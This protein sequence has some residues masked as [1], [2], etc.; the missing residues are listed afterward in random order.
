MA[1][2]QVQGPDGATLSFPE[3]TDREVMK[4]AMA[5]R[6]PKQSASRETLPAPQIT[7]SQPSTGVGAF[8]AFG[9]G[10]VDGLS[11]GGIDYL[12]AGLGALTGLNGYENP[13]ASEKSGPNVSFGDF[14]GNLQRIRDFNK[15]VEAENPISS[16]TGNIVGST[17]G[18][19]KLMKSGLTA[20]RLAA[21][22]LP[23][24]QSKLAKLLTVAGV[25]AV[26]GAGYQVASNIGH[27]DDPTNG[28][29]LTAALGAATPAI[30][31]GVKKISDA[32]GLTQGLDKGSKLVFDAFTRNAERLGVPPQQILTQMSQPAP[33]QMRV[34]DALGKEGPALGRN[35]RDMSPDARSKLEQFAHERMAG[36]K[37]RLMNDVN[38]AGGLPE[39]QDIQALIEANSTSRQPQ[40]TNAYNQA[41]AAGYDLP[42][43][44]FE[45][46]LA[47]PAVKSAM[48][49]AI[50]TTKNR[51]AL[52]GQDENSQLA[53]YDA[54][55][56]IL[57]RKGRMEGNSELSGLAKMLRQTVDD[58]IPEYAGAR[59]LA[60]Q[61]FQAE[62]A[63]QLGYDG[64]KAKPGAGYVDKVLAAQKNNPDEIAKGYASGMAD[65]IAGTTSIDQAL[66]KFTQSMDGAAALKSALGP[67]AS[68]V[69]KGIERERGN[70]AMQREL[71]GGSQTARLLMETGLG[72]GLGAGLGFYQG[73]DMSSAAIGAAAGAGGRHLV[74]K[75]NENNRQKL[76]NRLADILLNG[77]TSHFSDTARK[78]GVSDAQLK[79]INDFV[80]LLSVGGG[81]AVSAQ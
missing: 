59:D 26:D 55:K 73:G 60:R 21:K 36:A 63:L 38:S 41:K 79:K 31:A 8:G 81:V 7:P 77:G 9:N 68:V 43:D 56:K 74:K 6:Y 62:E 40:I 48:D 16:T 24:A 1:D 64:A 76:G 5:K 58:N 65:A 32:T 27:G 19:G 25:G 18:V 80:K 2:I 53:V 20:E 11:F 67:K 78:V 17:L 22:A 3:G 69:E 46:L 15:R 47:A 51:I 45:S 71:T 12:D 72:G 44:P 4:A 75:M 28:I 57:D 30:G 14:S 66:G 13:F 52:G 70:M 29:G 23:T 61:K 37:D 10:A 35:A 50:A 54:A 33:Y 42:R 39:R 49:E 34:I